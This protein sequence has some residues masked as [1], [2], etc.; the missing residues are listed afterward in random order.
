MTILT[1]GGNYVITVED[2][3]QLT[4][5]Y[6]TYKNDITA[7]HANYALLMSQPGGNTKAIPGLL[8]NAINL[9]KSD[10]NNVMKPIVPGSDG[11]VAEFNCNPGSVE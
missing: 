4:A 9:Y 11:N 8:G 3:A 7:Y 5:A 6:T 2:R 1:P 10:S